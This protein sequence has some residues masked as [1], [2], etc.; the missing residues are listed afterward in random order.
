VQERTHIE[1]DLAL[2]LDVVQ[3]R[4]HR[5]QQEHFLV[6]EG[7]SVRGKERNEGYVQFAGKY[8]VDLRTGT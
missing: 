8:L 5:G 2:A 4:I 7:H 6:S 3:E 1:R